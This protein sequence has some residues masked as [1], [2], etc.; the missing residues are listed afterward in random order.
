M[1]K[2]SV[3]NPRCP[4]R[5]AIPARRQRA[6]PQALQA[7]SPRQPRGLCA[8]PRAHLPHH[9]ELCAG[10]RQGTEAPVRGVGAKNKVK[11]R[12]DIIAHLQLQTKK[13]AEVQ[14]RS[15]HDLTALGPGSATL[16]SPSTTSR[17]QRCLRRR[18]AAKRWMAQPNDYLIRGQ[19]D[20]AAACAATVPDGHPHRLLEQIGGRARHLG[21]LAADRQR[22]GRR[23]GIR[24]GTALGHSADA[25]IPR[26]CRSCGPTAAPT[27][28]RT[29]RR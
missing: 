8:D 23:S 5:A 10:D 14:A 9:C 2:S 11:V 22:R 16:T 21:G 17:S 7:Y 25:E 1:A 15:G 4:G 18:R 13:A 12:L 6:A 28:R 3:S 20:A 19:V 27:W 24:F 29:A 26:F